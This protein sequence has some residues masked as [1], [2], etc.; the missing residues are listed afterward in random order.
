MM[1][2]LSALVCQSK[3]SGTALLMSIGMSAPLLVG[4]AMNLCATEPG[5]PHCIGPGGDTP[6]GPPAALSVSPV[7]LSLSQGG[8][9]TIKLGD[10]PQVGA[11]AFLRRAQAADLTL[12]PVEQAEQ[13]VTIS[14]AQLSG[15]SPGLAQL[16]VMLA[17]HT[18]LTAPLRLFME[19]TFRDA[20]KEYDTK[21]ESNYPIW[22]G[23]GDQGALY[24]LNSFPPFSGSSERQ[25]RL[26]D[27]QYNK[28]VFAPRSPQSFG[29][30]RGYPISEQGP[31]RGAVIGDQV[32]AISKN[33]VN[34]QF[35]IL[36]DLCSVKVQTCR[37]LNPMSLEFQKI[38]GL[39]ADR[40][41]ALV[42]V[43]TDTTTLVYRGTD[44]SPF[45]ERLSLAGMP[46][47]NKGALALV[48]VGDLDG[49]TQPDLV[50]AH[51]SGGA[52]V[53]LR[54]TDS[55]ELRYSEA[56]SQKLG[57][58]LGGLPTALA[59]GDVDGDGLDDVALGRSGSVM[60]LVNQGEGGFT[61][62]PAIATGMV[63]AIDSIAL[64][65]IDSSTGNR[66]TDL[67]VASSSGQRLAVLINQASF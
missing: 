27:Y 32:V 62:A 13:S 12:G 52:S 17:D 56:Y 33:P 25:L 34:Q 21:P 65:N 28:G 44:E 41:G 2:K 42:A 29:A 51:Q 14:A 59:V 53:F 46:T 61:A 3:V 9:L 57:A 49:D 54:A 23:I 31:G 6:G 4:C 24:T 30:Y 63:T 45:A 1:K 7:R 37:Q 48:A 22:A 11:R 55:K 40:R 5:D 64:G 15:R 43:Q 36:T 47:A 26:V 50:Q 66:S 20:P 35:P 39:A 38:L 58:A 19:P 60:L 67:A 16:V 10:Q 18:E 8:A